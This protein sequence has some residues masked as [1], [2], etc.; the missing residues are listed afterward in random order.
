MKKPS[1]QKI[2][3][4]RREHI[5]TLFAPTAP[6][7]PVL[8]S[9]P[10]SGEQVPE[11]INALVCDTEGLRD[12]MLQDV[13]RF[14]DQI[15]REVPASGATLMVAKMS[16]YVVDLNRAA[17]DVSGEV[18]EGTEAKQGPGYY[19]ERGVVWARTTRRT[20]VWQRK[21]SPEEFETRVGRYHAPYHDSLRL[22]LDDMKAR[23][24]VAILVD[25]HSMPSKG[26]AGHGDEGRA[27]PD[28]NPGT[29]M[30]ASC[31]ASVRV[32]VASHLSDEGYE[33]RVDDPYKGGWITRHYGR[34]DEGVH[35][36]QIEINRRLYMDEV[37]CAMKSEGIARLSGTMS[38]LPQKLAAIAE[39]LRGAR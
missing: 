21:L 24:G 2:D 12:Q 26:R 17:D 16:R 33:V 22:L 30:G 27:R 38:R 4:S 31:G 11:D 29:V 8:V 37:T 13:D 1:A 39:G 15:W 23:F 28:I 9:V 34:P 32:C 19:G 20:P 25:A 35:A 10:H 36:I 7:I 3:N 5:A 6:A 14:V 18:V